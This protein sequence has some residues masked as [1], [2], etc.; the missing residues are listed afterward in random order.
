[1]KIIIQEQHLHVDQ[2]NVVANSSCS[3][4]QVGDNDQVVLYST[5]ET[6]PDG[7]QIGPFNSA[8]KPALCPSDKI[9]QLP[10]PSISKGKYR[11]ES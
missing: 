3:N 9:I 10:Q 6:P 11:Y 5:I 7:C 4:I 1:M 2:V 8:S